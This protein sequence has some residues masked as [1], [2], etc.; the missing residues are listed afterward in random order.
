MLSR[1]MNDL[2]LASQ[3]NGLTQ[4]PPQQQQQRQLPRQHT[5]F[6]CISPDAPTNP[7]LYWL[8]AFDHQNTKFI[9]DGAKGPLKLD[10][11]DILYAPNLMIDGKVSILIAVSG[12]AGP[13]YRRC[14]AASFCLRAT[15]I[16]CMPLPIAS[17]YT[18]QPCN[19]ICHITS[20]QLSRSG[21]GTMPSLAVHLEANMLSSL[22][23][24]RTVS[25]R[26]CSAVI[27]HRMPC[28]LISS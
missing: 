1:Q 10:L 22:L 27:R 20:P 19:F 25:R 8:G 23:L 3:D 2:G 18:Q 4:Q 16:L 17:S 7:V 28:V 13:L 12:I 21:N 26:L 24:W 11:G 15:L 5:H 9:L 14:V 6:L